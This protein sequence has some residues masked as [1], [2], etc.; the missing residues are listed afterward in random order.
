MDIHDEA[1]KLLNHP[2]I[3]D[4]FKETKDFYHRIIETSNFDEE[5]KRTDAYFMLRAVNELNETL[6]QFAAQGS[7]KQPKVKRLLPLE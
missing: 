7:I 5:D 2:M 3:S 1:S 6:K 4:F